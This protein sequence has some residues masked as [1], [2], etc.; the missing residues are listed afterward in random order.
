MIGVLIGVD[1]SHEIT[2]IIRILAQWQG[3]QRVEERQLV[4]WIDLDLGRSD[5]RVVESA[6]SEFQTETRFVC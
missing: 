4:V 1:P 2:P 6:D 3:G 5:G